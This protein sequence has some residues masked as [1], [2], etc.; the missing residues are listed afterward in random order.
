ML[1][2]AEE[3]I[4][5]NAVIHAQAFI[6]NTDWLADVSLFEVIWNGASIESLLEECSDKWCNNVT[7]EF[8]KLGW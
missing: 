2:V 3:R 5:V 7:K 6:R 4:T 1:S 8:E